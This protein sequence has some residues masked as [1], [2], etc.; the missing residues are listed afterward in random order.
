M[1]ATI[2]VASRIDKEIRK[3]SGVYSAARVKIGLE[4]A[5]R[6][7]EVKDNKLYKLLD[8]KAYPSF[9]KYIESLGIKYTTAMELIGLYETYIL[10]GGYSIEE[11]AEISYHKLTQIKPYLFEKREGAYKL[12][13][14]KTELKKWVKEAESDLS[15]NDLRIKRAEAEVGEH[16]HNWLHFKR[17]NLCKIVEYDN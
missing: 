12:S 9:N 15:I 11:L 6:L 5:S 10:I 4:L 2:T 17:C 16:E 7:K 8:E 3:L 13:K 1:I 14:S